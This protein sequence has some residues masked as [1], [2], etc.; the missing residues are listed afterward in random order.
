MSLATTS[1][2]P[3]RSLESIRN[4]IDILLTMDT[5]WIKYEFVAKFSGFPHVIAVII[6]D[7][8]Q[9][10]KLRDWIP[11]E[12]LNR[13]YLCSNPNAFLAGVIPD[14]E[15]A[16]KEHASANPFAFDYIKQNADI[17]IKFDQKWWNPKVVEWLFPIGIYPIE[18][19]SRLHLGFCESML[20]VNWLLNNI[21]KPDAIKCLSTN[22]LAIDVLRQN[23]DLVN[24]D[25]IWGNSAAVDI[26]QARITAGD[27]INWNWLSW[28]SSTWAIDLLE[29]NRDKI[30][31]PMFSE[32]PG[33]FEIADNKSKKS[34]MKILTGNDAVESDDSIFDYSI[35]RI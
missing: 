24:L 35:V 8:L 26:L 30:H 20:A 33:I 1:Y 12:K 7:Y 18:N 9:I 5:S 22:P 15:S 29:N 16:S 2:N 27:P 23:M 13:R 11:G 10:F 3:K 14:W 21:P 32:N 28:N 6:I 34:L 4:Q 25:S 31:W 17:M 19:N